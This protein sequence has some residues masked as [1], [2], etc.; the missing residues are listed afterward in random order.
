MRLRARHNG[1]RFTAALGRGIVTA[2]RPFV[3]LVIACASLAAAAPALAQRLPGPIVA[4]INPA[5]LRAPAPPAPATNP[6]EWVTPN[7][8]P[9]NALVDGVEGRVRFVVSVD[10]DG[11]PTDC[12][13]I[14]SSGDAELDSVACAKVVERGSFTPATDG[15]GRRV[16]G[17]WYNAVQWRIPELM[18]PPGPSYFTGSFVVE[19][20]GTVTQCKVEK[21]EPEAD[22]AEQAF[23]AMMGKFEPIIDADGNPVRQR[24]RIMS[25]VVHEDLPQ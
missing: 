20:D 11:R 17:E 3:S 4:P 9:P 19:A 21:A 6:G 7:D 16:K 5:R 23:C 12:K 8:Y 1:A 2:M 24:V 10:K 22:Q 15:K 14:E 18:P 13:V 25:R